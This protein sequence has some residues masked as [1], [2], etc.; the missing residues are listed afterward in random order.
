MVS[1]DVQTTTLV[2]PREEDMREF[3]AL[4][5]GVAWTLA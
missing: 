1:A 5:G 4:A 2:R 3:S